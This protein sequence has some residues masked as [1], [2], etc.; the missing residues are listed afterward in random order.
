[1]VQ[2]A[3]RFKYKPLNP[4]RFNG[5]THSVSR[6][7]VTARWLVSEENECLS[8]I[9]FWPKKWLQHVFEQE[10]IGLANL[11]FIG[12]SRGAG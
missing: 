4:V 12:H 6:L 1:M 5:Q 9:P 3:V 8:L 10:K 2:A 7:L 11:L